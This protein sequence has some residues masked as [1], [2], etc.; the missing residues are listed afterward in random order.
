MQYNQSNIS[1]CLIIFACLAVSGCASVASSV[2]RGFAEDLATAILDNEDIEMV[3][4]GAP[5]YLI[6]IDSLV[7]RSPDDGFLLRQ[8]ATLHS[9]YAGAFVDDE[10]RASL[11][12]EKA[13]T[14]ALHM[15]CVSLRDGCDLRTRPYKEF[16]IWVADQ[17]VA[18]VPVLYTLASTWAGWIQVNSNDFNAIADLARVKEI[19]LKVTE[20]DP[21]YENGNAYLY[22]GVFETLL[23]PGMGGRPE[24]GRT[25]F[26]QAMALS[27]GQN[28]MA[29]V[30]FAEQYARLVFDRELHDALLQDVMESEFKIPGLTLMNTVA[31]EQAQQLIGTANDYF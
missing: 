30:M 9:A 10:R 1:R 26:E 5:S 2:T 4:D 25:Y 29:K 20:L 8:S 18:A 21:G 13:K 15:A 23:P 11:L 6:L 22:L 16:A 17:K 14:Q 31:R 24:L 7:T 12:H 28:Q 27:G 19:M 3:R